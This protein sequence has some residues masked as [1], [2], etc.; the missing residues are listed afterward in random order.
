MSV[1]GD[2]YPKIQT[3]FQR[4]AANKNVIIPGAW[5]TPEFAYL[6]DCPWRWT[7]KV[8]GT[9]IRV[10]W[11]GESITI[12]GRT[13][14]AQVPTSL[15]AALGFLN[16]A[17]LWSELSRDA[18]NVTVYGEG[19]GARIQSGGQYRADQSLIVFDVKVGQWWLHEDDVADIAAKLGLDTVPVLPS[20]SLNVAIETVR[21]GLI[22]SAWKDA[23]IEGLVGRPVVDLYSRKGDRILAKIKVKDWRDYERLARAGAL[24]NGEPQ[25]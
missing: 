15:I 17:A 7:E 10:H 13:N 8:D 9:N 11:N 5:T 19:Y 12:G 21:A 20:Y 2:E 1:F 6:A 3:V 18:D 23:R 14:N 24:S 4:D 25:P 22:E 16:D